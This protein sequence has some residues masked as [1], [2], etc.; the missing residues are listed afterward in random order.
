MCVSEWNSGNLVKNAV[1]RIGTET[2]QTG[3]MDLLGEMERP[4]PAHGQYP[5]AR[6]SERVSGEAAPI[7]QPGHGTHCDL[8]Q[9]KPLCE[10][11]INFKVVKTIRKITARHVHGILGGSLNAS[12]RSG[13][14][15][16]SMRGL[17]KE[18]VD[19]SGIKHNTQ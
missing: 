3:F 13:R 16:P 1:V 5:E 11:R 7:S 15:K 9:R 18:S 10:L 2:L 19:I 17:Q 14:R 4:R 8:W 6:Y 12:E